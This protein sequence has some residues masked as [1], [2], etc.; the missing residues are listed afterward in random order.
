MTA[1]LYQRSLIIPSPREISALIAG[2]TQGSAKQNDRSR[3]RVRN[4][5]FERKTPK[6]ITSKRSGPR[7][8]LEANSPRDDQSRAPHSFDDDRRAGRNILARLRKPNRVA[9]AR[10]ALAIDERL[11][12]GADRSDQLEVTLIQQLTGKRTTPRQSIKII[13]GDARD[14]DR[15]RED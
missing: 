7:L 12:C 2:Q 15:N 13:P 9:D 5:A 10:L 1:F 11:A 14:D 8:C 6:R 4:C 3:E